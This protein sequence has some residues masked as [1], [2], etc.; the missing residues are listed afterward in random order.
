MIS[1]FTVAEFFHVLFGM[2]WV[3]TS[4][5]VELVLAPVVKR[6]KV[7]GEY[8]QLLPIMGRTSAVQMM[9]GLLVIATGVV[10][11]LLRYD[12]GAVLAISSGKLIILSL[13]LVLAALINGIV[14]LKP[15]AMKIVKTSW[16]DDPNAVIP[17][18]VAKLQKK[19]FTGSLVNT[20]IVVVVL[21]LMVVAATGGF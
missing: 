3:G 14:F 10:Y 18:V 21:F 13:V 6:A 1:E 8:R 5:Y 11:L 20:S 17:E 4:I 2:M 15:T 12:L 19:L 9:S 16:P 7:V